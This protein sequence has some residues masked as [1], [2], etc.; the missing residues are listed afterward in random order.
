MINIQQFK[1]SKDTLMFLLIC[2]GGVLLF[3]FVGIIPNQFAIQGVT[4]DIMQL[5][6][7]IEKQKYMQPFFL[8]YLKKNRELKNTEIKLPPKKR[9]NQNAI[10]TF[11]DQ[12]R[13]LA[14]LNHLRLE[15]FLPDVDRLN[16]TTKT[17]PLT[18]VVQG[19]LYGFQDFYQNICKLPMIDGIEAIYIRTVKQTKEMQLNLM[20]A[21]E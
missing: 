20:L 10:N 1:L 6:S 16:P 19:E 5:E 18:I 4:E 14:E 3:V 12:L 8:D 2:T 7:D 13:Q 9:L 11:G 17:I 21:L 15:K